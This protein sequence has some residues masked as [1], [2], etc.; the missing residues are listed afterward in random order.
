VC[1]EVK[2]S[3]KTFIGNMDINTT[4]IPNAS[5]WIFWGRRPTVTDKTH[6]KSKSSKSID[7]IFIG[8]I[9]NSVQAG[10]RSDKW[11]DCIS[12]FHLTNGKNHKFTHE[13][14]MQK[15]STAKYGL[16]MKGFG[17]KCHREVE[18]MAVG[19]IPLCVGDIPMHSYMDPPQEGKHY[20]RV[21]TP[22]DVTRIIKETPE[23]KRQ[24]MSDA[25]IE[26]YS[27]NVFA[28][29][30]FYEFIQYVLE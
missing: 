11:K 24:E 19:T 1:D 23:A 20:F 25:C 29:N 26:W 17:V 27:K 10:N 30:W 16:C 9:E 22:E 2:N 8:N 5:P 13:E 15:L 7:S 12:E 21:D 3:L 6:E 4:N 14:Y 18:S 28:K